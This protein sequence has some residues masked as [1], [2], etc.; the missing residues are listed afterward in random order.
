MNKKENIFSRYWHAYGGFS[1]LM[2]SYYFWISILISCLLY[3]FWS[4]EGWWDDVL[5]IMPDLVG[6]SLGGFAMW[7]AIGD[8]SFRQLISGVNEDGTPSPYMGKKQ[9]WRRTP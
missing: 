4:R 8:D 3:P 2:T 6:F 9:P 7:I 1:A 5:G